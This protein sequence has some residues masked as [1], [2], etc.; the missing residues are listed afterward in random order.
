[1]VFALGLS[2]GKGKTRSSAKGTCK[3]AQSCKV[4]ILNKILK[5]SEF[6]S[7]IGILGISNIDKINF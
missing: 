3:R 1:M 5:P 7:L 6:V 4:Q 2:T